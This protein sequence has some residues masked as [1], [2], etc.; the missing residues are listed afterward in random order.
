M[1]EHNNKFFALG[2]ALTGGALVS[3]AL[4]FKQYWL[5]GIGVTF[6]VVSINS[7]IYSISKK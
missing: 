7:A 1:N 3:L 4:L 6:F 2:F 5:L